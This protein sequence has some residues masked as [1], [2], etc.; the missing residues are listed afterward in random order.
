MYSVCILIYVSM[1]LYSYPSTH[2]I[3][4]PPAGGA[5]EQF[6]VQLE[7]TIEWTQR[8]TPRPWSS[9]VWDALGG[10][11]RASLDIHLEAEI[12]RVGRCTWRPWSS[13]FRDTLGGCNRANLEMHFEAVIVRPWRQESSEIGG[14]LG[15]CDWASLEI[16]LEDVIERIWRCTLR[17]WSSEFG[18]A[19]GGNDHVNLEAV[20]E[21]VWRCSWR[22]WLSEFGDAL[23][24]RD[25]ARLDEYLEVLHG[26]RAGCWDS[27]KQLVNSQPW[28]CENVTL[29]L[30]SHGELADGGRWCR[31][32][33]RKLKLHQ[34]K[35]NLLHCFYLVYCTHKLKNMKSRFP[36]NM[37]LLYCSRVFFESS[38]CCFQAPW[39]MY[40]RL[41]MW[42]RALEE[43]FT[44]P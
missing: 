9:E 41:R 37:A 42:Q 14:I 16:H 4:G 18:D 30:S 23:G 13:E 39:P 34:Q 43:R 15:G 6:E 38:R 12:E 1:Y 31:E 5:W 26:W 28:E 36:W 24:G 44:L 22:L 2:G 32:V 27:I 8:Y 7:M 19:L 11:D 29:L 40:P 20:I 21:R 33:C 10:R 25:R 17:P 3:S 35:L